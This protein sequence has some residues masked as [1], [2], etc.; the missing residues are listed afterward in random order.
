MN[1]FRNESELLVPLTESFASTLPKRE[2]PL[3]SW[4]APLSLAFLSLEANAHHV[5]VKRTSGEV[6]C[7]RA[8]SLLARVT[9][10]K[11]CL[12]STCF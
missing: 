5:W 9:Q 6:A 10:M 11:A 1:K 4:N 2:R 8:C 12:Q 3:T 7:V